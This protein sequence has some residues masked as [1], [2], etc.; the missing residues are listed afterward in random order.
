MTD[1]ISSDDG[2]QW[3]V[4]DEPSP[5]QAARRFGGA[6]RTTAMTAAVSLVLVGGVTTAAVR[7]FAPGADVADVVPASAFAIAQL[8]LSLPDGQDEATAHLV[9][10]FPGVLNG[11]GSIRDR[12]LGALFKASTNPH[13]D[14]SALKPW[15]GDHVAVVGWADSS[16]TPQ[17]E[18]VVQ[19]TDDTAARKAIRDA[20]STTGIVFTH[21]FAVLAPTQADADAA[22]RAADKSSLADSATYTGDIG[23]L[24]GTPTATAWLD[25]AGMAK[26]MQHAFSGATGGPGADILSTTGLGNGTGRLVAGLRVSDDGDNSAVQL[27]VLNR[28]GKP[29]ARAT[30]TDRLRHLPTGTLAAAAIADPGGVVREMATAIT[31]P[32]GL[33]F[34]GFSA[35]SGALSS[36]STSLNNPGSTTC[37]DVLPPPSDAKPIDPLAE[38][39]KQV[40]IAIPGDLVSLLGSDAVVAYGGISGDGTPKIGLRSKPADINAAADVVTKL[41]NKL[42]GLDVQLAEQLAGSDFVLATS[43]DYA[44]DL[45]KAGSLGTADRFADAMRGMPSSV[46]FATY[47]DLGAIL[48]LA[49][50]GAV[51]QLDH[52]TALGIWSADVDGTTATRIR[53]IVH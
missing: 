43:D 26:A 24:E 50:H 9:K 45:A 10:R 39:S 28:G 4:A 21:G 25:G 13:V 32:L 37:T 53:L 23:A 22:V 42:A 51:P 27:D 7:N 48:P 16:G 17:V 12:L 33:F 6:S 36:C 40:G 20:S 34:G 3:P 11:S 1:T 52:V 29:S 41:R 47:V 46:G 15:L 5:G 31:G 49:T 35:E 2:A 30:S 19:S 44:A 18:Y 8:D 38:I 14:Y